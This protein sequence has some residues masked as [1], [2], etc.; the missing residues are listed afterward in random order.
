VRL[1]V[2]QEMIRRILIQRRP[3]AFEEVGPYERQ[4]QQHGQPEPERDDLHGAVTAAARHVGE[5]VP[6]GDADTRAEASD[7]GHEGPADQVQ[8]RGNDDDAADQDQ[9]HPGVADRPVQQHGNR[10]Q[11]EAGDEQPRRRG[12]H[13]IMAEHPEGRRVPELDHRG[14]RKTDEQDHCAP[15]R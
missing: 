13:F 8:R 10:D 11:R 12:R 2:D 5:P 9:Q 15:A 14:Q 7:R 1:D 3:P 6:P 4:Q